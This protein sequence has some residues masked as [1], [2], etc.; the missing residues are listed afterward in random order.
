MRGWHVSQASEPG[1]RYF[2]IDITPGIRWTTIL[3]PSGAGP[4]RLWRL[5]W[6]HVVASLFLLLRRTVLNCHLR[7]DYQSVPQQ[8]RTLQ[9]VTINTLLFYCFFLFQYGHHCRRAYLIR[10]LNSSP[11]TIRL[12]VLGAVPRT[13]SFTKYS[14]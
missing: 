1:K 7:L 3:R 2:A 5:A 4:C 10:V 14:V 11:R 13:L 12:A 9:A 8:N 6:Y